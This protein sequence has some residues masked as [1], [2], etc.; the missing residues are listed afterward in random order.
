MVGDVKTP[1]YVWNV[2]RNQGDVWTIPLIVLD[3]NKIKYFIRLTF[4]PLNIYFPE[5]GK[6]NQYSQFLVPLYLPTLVTI[7]VTE[8]EGEVILSNNPV[9]IAGQ[10][11]E[12]LVSGDKIVPG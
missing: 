4:T 2:C 6:E 9:V 5:F 10:G 3:I 8:H 7:V 12:D 11:W 1:L